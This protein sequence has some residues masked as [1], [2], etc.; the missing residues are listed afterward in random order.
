MKIEFFFGP[1]EKPSLNP[2]F[3]IQFLTQ[4]QKKRKETKAILN[5][6]LERNFRNNIDID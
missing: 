5:F 2:T 4:D 6:L 3:E 1:F